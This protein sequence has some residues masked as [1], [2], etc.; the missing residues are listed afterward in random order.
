MEMNIN[1]PKY[2]TLFD[3]MPDQLIPDRENAERLIHGAKE[4]LISREKNYATPD[5]VNFVAVLDRYIELFDKAKSMVAGE[6]FTVEF[7]GS[8]GVPDIVDFMI[9]PIVKKPRK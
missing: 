2:G 3:V 5:E 7:K 9:V 6:R 1:R 8:V 4:F